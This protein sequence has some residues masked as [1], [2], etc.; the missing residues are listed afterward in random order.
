MGSIILI[1]LGVGGAVYYGH[2]TDR[3]EYLTDRNF[4]VLAK[5]SRDLTVR[6]NS[7][8]TAWDDHQKVK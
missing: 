1:F 4:R 3:Q 7:Y 2:V 8:I 5:W 6:L